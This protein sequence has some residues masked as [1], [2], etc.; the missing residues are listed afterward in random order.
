[1][2]VVF[3]LAIVAGVFSKSLA[4]QQDEAFVQEEGLCV[5]LLDRPPVCV[6]GPLICVVA[7]ETIFQHI[8]IDGTTCIVPYHMLE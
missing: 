8:S 7:G 6:R 3:A 1:M 4:V 2:S 5:Q